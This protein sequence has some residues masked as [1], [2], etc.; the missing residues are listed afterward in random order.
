MT[1]MWWFLQPGDVAPGPDQLQAARGARRHQGDGHTGEEEET[2][3]AQWS[4][5]LCS[6]VRIRRPSK[7]NH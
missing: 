6:I 5:D 1:K 7:E 3:V 2:T 4:R